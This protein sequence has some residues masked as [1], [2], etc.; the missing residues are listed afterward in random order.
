MSDSIVAIDDAMKWGFGWKFGPFETWDALG[1]EKS[2]A[3]MK[4]EGYAVPAWIDEMLAAGHTSFYKG[5]QYYD[6]ASQTYVEKTVNPKELK[7]APLAK[8]NGII[9]ENGGARLID[10]GDDV[11]AL[12]FTSPNNA[13]IKA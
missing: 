4:A 5:E 8:S 7:L 13:M 11:V 12:E 3:R 2:V 1:V 10:I 9:L 6:Q